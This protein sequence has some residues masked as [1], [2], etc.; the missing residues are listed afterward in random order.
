MKARVIFYPYDI[1]IAFVI[2]VIFFVIVLSLRHL[3][4]MNEMTHDKHSDKKKSMSR[5]LFNVSLPNYG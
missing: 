5:H 4:Q 3:M 1:V 2:T